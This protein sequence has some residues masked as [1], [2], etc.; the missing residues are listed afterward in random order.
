MNIIGIVIGG[1]VAFIVVMIG[2]FWYF[3]RTK[4]SGKKIP[5]LLYND[6]GTVAKTLNAKVKVDK[7]NRSDRTFVFEENPSVLQIKKPTL[8]L[9]GV[10]YRQITLGARGEYVYLEGNRISYDDYKESAL[11]SEDVAVATSLILENNREFEN[12][13]QKTTAALVIGMA[14]IALLIMIGNIYATITLVG[15]SKDMLAVAQENSKTVSGLERAATTNAE[16][17]AINA[18]I[19]AGLRGDLNLTRRLE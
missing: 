10:G 2:V 16:V 15:N 5:F 17:A 12:P 11:T 14:I 7:H 6:D 13:M 3:T 18:E 19:L 9:N 1:V 4:G 8:Y